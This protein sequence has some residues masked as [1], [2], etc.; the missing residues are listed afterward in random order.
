MISLSSLETLRAHADVE[1]ADAE[2]E[3][4]DAD[5]GQRSAQP[6]AA[7]L[8]HVDMRAVDGLLKTFEAVELTRINQEELPHGRTLLLKRDNSAAGGS[9]YYHNARGRSDDLSSRPWSN[10]LRI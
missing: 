6:P 1:R 7:E 8:H 10:H 5:M 9:K 2:G 4:A 3:I